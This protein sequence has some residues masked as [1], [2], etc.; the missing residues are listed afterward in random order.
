M[1]VYRIA[2]KEFIEDMTGE[3]ARLYGG[4]WNKKGTRA[5]YTAESRSLATVE[6]LVHLPLQIMPQQMCIAELELP[7][8]EFDTITLNDLPSDWYSYPASDTLIE[9][10]EKWLHENK[11]LYLKVPSAVVKNEWNIIINPQHKHFH[12]VKIISVEDYTFDSRLVK[13]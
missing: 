9:I 13:R 10:G 2:K 12:K 5:L 4:R 1:N 6:Y 11:T 8:N 3:G 7:N